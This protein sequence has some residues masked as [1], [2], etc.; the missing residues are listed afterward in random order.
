MRGKMH[1]PKFWWILISSVCY[2]WKKLALGKKYWSLYTSS[3]LVQQ[4]SKLLKITN[5]M[6][7]QYWW[8]NADENN[9]SPARI[10][11]EELSYKC[12]FQIST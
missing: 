9:Q 12:K 4:L 11:L 8:Y 5:Q 1:N 3:Y 7:E 6:I 2:Q 10:L